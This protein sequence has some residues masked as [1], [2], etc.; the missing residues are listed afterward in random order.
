[1]PNAEHFWVELFPHSDVPPAR[2]VPMRLVH[3]QGRP[4]LLLPQIPA[5]A[6]ACLD[7]YSA[8]RPLPRLLRA[9]LRKCFSFGLYPRC[10]RIPLTLS[11]DAPLV[12]FLGRLTSGNESEA[13]LFGMLGGNPATEG[14]RCLL[15]TLDE[16]M[17]PKSVI[18][19]GVGT[20]A[21]KLISR[22]TNFLRRHGGQYPAVPTLR[23][24]LDLPAFNAFALDHIP[25]HS[26]PPGLCDGI[27]PVLSAWIHSDHKARI[28][29]LEPW[30]DLE[31][32]WPAGGRDARL[33]STLAARFVNPVLYHGDFA[34]WNIRVAGNQPWQVLDWE[35]GE[36][37]GP[38]TWDWY[39]YLIQ[40]TILV[41]RLPLPAI[42]DRIR[43][44]W[45][46]PEFQAYTTA[47]STTGL[48]LDLLLGYLHYLIHVLHPAEG[49][50]LANQILT[51]LPRAM[52][53]DITR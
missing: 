6:A 21:R 49:L 5:A 40:T 17:R 8:Q 38:P 28:T 11:P 10:P 33:E 46:S 37:A 50:T 24:E 32:A 22:E 4:F 9:L 12:R 42:I 31:T 44:L 48:E 19:T 35:R 25:G 41:D 52:G 16:A 47:T 20:A 2:Q 43:S 18:K 51:A 15:L 13:P 36:P 30:L 1:M 53:S 39:H 26:P 23:G 27:L 29:T 7:L 34:P 45:A 3:R 14:R